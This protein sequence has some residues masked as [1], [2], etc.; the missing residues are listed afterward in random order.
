MTAKK[1]KL[2]MNAWQIVTRA[3]EEG[4]AYGYRRAHKHTDKPTEEHLVG[5]IQTAVMSA[6]SDVV[7]WER[8]D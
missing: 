5:E 2:K 7:I 3:V 8:D 4:V 6:I 1:A